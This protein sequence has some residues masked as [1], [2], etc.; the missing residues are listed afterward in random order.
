[1][2]AVFVEDR[3]QKEAAA[4]Y[5][6]TYGSMRQLVNEFR[7]C[8]EDKTTATEEFFFES[9]NAHRSFLVF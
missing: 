8:L 4:M 1:L 7:R 5:G 9:G 2:R 3:S 6:Y